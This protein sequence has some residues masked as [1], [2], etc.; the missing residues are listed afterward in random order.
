MQPRNRTG[1]V[2]AVVESA[3]APL[4]RRG[5]GAP[6]SA[7]NPGRRGF[8]SWTSPGKATRASMQKSLLRRL[9]AAPT[10]IC[11]RD[12]AGDGFVL[13][14]GRKGCSTAWN[15][16]PISRAVRAL[17]T[18]R[19]VAP[20]ISPAEKTKP[21]PAAAML[22]HFPKPRARDLGDGIFRS[23]RA[24]QRGVHDRLALR[25]D[26]HQ[27]QARLAAPACPPD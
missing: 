3:V 9:A 6:V 25:V 15:Q 10:G 2:A 22:I 24:G 12:P 5:L 27:R 11:A 4:C 17:A 13:Q 21:S 19:P 18:Q 26:R 1:G 23:I 16:V 7:S 20:C 14:R 8:E